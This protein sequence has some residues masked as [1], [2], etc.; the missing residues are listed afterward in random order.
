MATHLTDAELVD[1][2]DGALTAARAAHVETCARC[3]E[4][5]SSLGA[6]LARARED[7]VPEPSP[8]FW[9]HFSARVRDAL[10]AEPAPRTGLRLRL[11]FAGAAAAVVVL[12]SA[13][14]LTRGIPF[15]P[16]VTDHSIAEISRDQRAASAAASTHPAVPEPLDFVLDGDAD[17]ELVRVVADGLQWEDAPDAGLHARPGSAEAVALEMTAAERQELTRLMAEE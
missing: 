2:A 8:L 14:M 16:T 13:V 11:P 17:W 5:A 1:Y 3:G 12:A 6:V 7:A 9:E 15:R 10:D 4:A